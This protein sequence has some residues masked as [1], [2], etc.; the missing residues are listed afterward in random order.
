MINRKKGL[1]IFVLSMVVV[2]KS[3][4]MRMRVLA[5]FTVIRIGISSRRGSL[6]IYYGNDHMGRRLRY[7]ITDRRSHCIISV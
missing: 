5:I 4:Q 7:L 2:S 1:G 6:T 3:V